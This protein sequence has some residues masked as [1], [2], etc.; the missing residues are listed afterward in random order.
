MRQSIYGLVFYALLSLVASLDWYICAISAFLLFVWMSCRN[1]VLWRRL[2]QRFEMLGTQ[3]VTLTEAGMLVEGDGTGVR[4][5]V[6]W[7]RIGRSWLRPDMLIVQQTNG[8]FHLLPTE[9]LRR[10]QAEEMYAYVKAHAG[11]QDAPHIAPPAELLSETPVRVTAAPAQWR[12]FVNYVMRA[13]EPGRVLL[14]YVALLLIG[15][16]GSMYLLSGGSSV[17]SIRVLVFLVLVLPIAL[18]PGFFARAMRN[19]PAPGYLHVHQKT[20]LAQLDN[21]A[22]TVLPTTLFDSARQLRHGIVYNTRLRSSVLADATD[23]PFPFLPAPRKARLWPHVIA[24]FVVVVVLPVVSAL[25]ALPPED[26]CEDVFVEAS[27]RGDSLVQY[28]EE[29]LPPREY[30]GRLDCLY[31]ADSDIIIME[32]E[33]GLEAR[34]FLHEPS[35]SE[36]AADMATADED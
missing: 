17:M 14:I 7:K 29:I 2:E 15:L 16:G 9:K 3:F 4:G 6:P 28:V 27:E 20:V 22:W 31:F 26:D 12:E 25:S 34:M 23:S 33:S 8:L 10:E 13:A 36:E 5:F 32:W 21:G 11:A 19:D 35:M 1:W 24:L 30:P 18:N